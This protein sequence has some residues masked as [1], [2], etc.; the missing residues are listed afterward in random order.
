[1]N[2]PADPVELLK[3]LISIPSVNPMG[4]DV[5]GEEYLEKRMTEYLAGW[6][7]AHHIPFRQMEVAP[8]R[9]NVVGLL[10]CS[11]DAPTIMLDAHQ[12][13]VPVEGMTIDPFL[14]T[15]ES[16]K[17]CGRGACDVKGGMAAIL[18]AVARLAS[19]KS[20]LPINVVISCCCDEERGQTG[21]KH[22][23]QSWQEPGPTPRPLFVTK[24]TMA[25]IAEPTGL[26]VVVAH[27]GATRW[28]IVTR[29]VSAHSSDPSRGESAIYKMAPILSALQKYA[30]QLQTERAGH[31]LCGKPTLSVGLINGG[32]SVNVVPDQC[33]IEIDRRTLPGEN[34]AEVMQDVESFLRERV[35]VDFEMLPPT[36]ISMPLSDVGNEQL[37]EQLGAAVEKVTGRRAFIGVPFGTH[38]STITAANVPAVVFGPGSIEQAHTKDEWL[39]IEQLEQA[40]ECFYQFLRSF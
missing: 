31:R 3:Q 12:D 19:Q 35:A 6:F 23:I 37:A 15:I 33:W 30:T 1:M 18:S 2:Y 26:D 25:V 14:P 21:I 36:T 7:D 28:R 13:T 40:S 20:P 5:D 22:L 39:D 17:I 4:R 38:A 27:R 9:S 8:R 24:P 29:G 32:T 34:A 11:P 10:S 16:G